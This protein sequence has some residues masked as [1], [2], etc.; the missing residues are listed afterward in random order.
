MQNDYQAYRPRLLEYLSSRGINIDTRHNFSCILPGHDDTTASMALRGDRLH[1]YGC[2]FDGD[3]YDVCGELDGITDRSE[4]YRRIAEHFGGSPAAPIVRQP[5]TPSFAPDPAAI[6]RVTEWL[7]SIRQPYADK[8]AEF[9]N[10][11][12]YDSDY[13]DPL[14]WWPGLKVAQ[15]Y[16]IRDDLE[17]AGI[18][19]PTKPRSAWTPA[20]AVVLCGVG[21]KLHYIDREGK[22]IKRE[23][24]GGHTFNP[25]DLP[26]GDRLILV[27]GELDEL[28]ARYAGFDETRAIGGT[29]GL[30]AD[31][32]REISTRGYLE[33]ILAFDNDDAGKIASGLMPPKQRRYTT[34]PQLLRSVGYSGSIR[35]AAI[36]EGCKDIDDAVKGSRIEEVKQ[37]IFNAAEVPE[38]GRNDDNLEHS[39]RYSGGLPVE[40]VD[41]G[42]KAGGMAPNGSSKADVQTRPPFQFLG[43]DDQAHY[44][45]PR[46]QNIALRIARG[47][48][49]I[50]DKLIEFAPAEWWHANFDREVVDKD[51]GGIKI[52]L[53][54]NA[55][56][57]WFSSTSQNHGVFTDDRI[58]GVG[59]HLDNGHAIVNTGRAVV[60]PGQKAV[61]YDDY[62]GDNAYCRSHI[63]LKVDG[64][65]WSRDDSA[66][67]IKQL[68]TFTFESNIAYYA[69]A[70]WCA[71]SPFA[72]I[73]FRRPHIWITAKKGVGKSWLMKE[74]MRPLTGETS[75][76]F[77]ENVTTEAAIRQETKKDNRSIYLD[78]FEIGSGGDGDSG[79]A[80]Y[81]KGII[82]GV[83]R[84]SRSSYSGERIFKGTANHN[85]ISFSTKNMFCFGSINVNINNAADKSRI[86]ICRM[87]NSNGIASPPKN[88]DGMRARMFL[89]LDRLIDD[90][91]ECTN[92]M[93]AFGHEQRVCDT[94]APLYAGFWRL[95]SESDFGNNGTNDDARMM[96]KMKESWE[97]ISSTAENISDEESLFQALFQ[98]RARL[99]A[100]EEK[101]VA[102]MLTEKDDMGRLRHSEALGKRGIRRY[103]IDEG[104]HANS[105]AIS[106]SNKDIREML[107]GASLGPNYKE[108]LKRH[109]SFIGTDTV[110]IGGVNQSAMLFRWTD[111]EARFF[112]SDGLETLP[113]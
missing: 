97:L 31:D 52:A 22:T 72:S 107:E 54:K 6:E 28:S 32:A 39:A 66:Y 71:V 87:D 89:H 13:A 64:E 112:N 63:E 101:T 105:L 79:T 56:M 17:P 35:Y 41:G 44:V 110:N 25:D 20:G 75:S 78:E 2:G 58:L 94:H 26:S 60:R 86:V 69:V 18:I 61:S 70:G 12:G 59:A 7:R 95:L 24:R 104:K 30:S 106:Q 5:A 3:I 50:K 108:V 67:F 8:L 1:C 73:L 77:S 81:E 38:G 27:E 84:L 68:K 80:R 82:D 100:G 21:F 43:F 113:F 9:A 10:A 57:E 4:Q 51:S 37:A 33:I 83:L 92:M 96:D 16:P 15:S 88:P 40:K 29:N 90:V 85:G 46:N 62:E 103:N 42:R 14:L 55:A 53:D 98:Y 93:L 74:I 36:P 19:D 49:A 99:E 47:E 76:L 91:Q 34:V 109:Y 11:R 45:L 65:P 102:E 48:K 23:S 111:L